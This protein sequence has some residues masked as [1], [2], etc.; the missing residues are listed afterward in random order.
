MT[1]TVNDNNCSDT[2][3]YHQGVPIIEEQEEFYNDDDQGSF[4]SITF[5]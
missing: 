5:T 2:R 4:C 3:I 1:T